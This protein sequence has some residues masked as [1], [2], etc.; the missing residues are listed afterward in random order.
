MLNIITEGV[1]ELVFWLARRVT[2]KERI[3]FYSFFLS[4]TNRQI[5]Q[6][7][8]ST[9]LLSPLSCI[10]II[11]GWGGGDN[12]NDRSIVC[13]HMGHRA[14]DTRIENKQLAIELRKAAPIQGNYNL[15]HV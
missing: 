14:T 5:S 11:I 8:C 10:I 2:E 12:D 3:R 9:L 6:P 1:I 7:S 4:G 13:L 15:N